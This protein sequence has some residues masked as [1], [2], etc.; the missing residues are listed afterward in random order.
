[1]NF[2]LKIKKYQNT[3]TG[4]WETALSDGYEKIRGKV[5]DIKMYKKDPR[6]IK[7]AEGKRVPTDPPEYLDNGYWTAKV[8]LSG[9]HLAKSI[10]IEAVPE[11]K[12]KNDDF[13]NSTYEEL[14]YGYLGDAKSMS[15]FDKE[16]IISLLKKEFNIFLFIFGLTLAFGLLVILLLKKL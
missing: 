10:P 7:N 4:K 13:N 2:E 6:T 12:I 15:F 16:R 1:M 11:E 14:D 3:S 8:E 9:I 5:F